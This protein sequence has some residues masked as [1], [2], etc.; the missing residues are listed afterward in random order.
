[1]AQDVYLTRHI[2]RTLRSAAFA[3]AAAPVASDDY[4]RG[5]LAALVAVALAFGIEPQEGAC[6]E[7]D[8]SEADLCEDCGTRISVNNTSGLCKRCE[9]LRRYAAAEAE[10]LRVRQHNHRIRVAAEWCGVATPG[11]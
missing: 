10:L 5:F 9:S 11:K 8:Y 2:E 7:A 6:L 3:V 4:R 1:M